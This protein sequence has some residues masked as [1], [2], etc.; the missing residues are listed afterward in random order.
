MEA[1][2]QAI[3]LKAIIAIEMSVEKNPRAGSDGPSPQWHSIA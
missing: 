1:G 3:E 2:S